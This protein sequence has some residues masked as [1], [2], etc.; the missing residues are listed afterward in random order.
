[1]KHSLQGVTIKQCFMNV[2]SVAM[3]RMVLGRGG[4]KA[5][6]LAQAMRLR[7][8]TRGK[9]MRDGQMGADATNMQM[10]SLQDEVTGC[11]WLVA[12]KWKMKMPN[13]SLGNCRNG[14][15]M[16]GARNAG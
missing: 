11:R 1:M 16:N 2:N 12:K 10:W 4:Y 15:P 8:S 5:I 7:D 3:G 13:P 6:A 14:D 9:A